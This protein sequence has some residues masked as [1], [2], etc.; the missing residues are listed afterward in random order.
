MLPF[1]LQNMP[2]FLLH[3]IFSLG[4]GVDWCW[5]VLF[6]FFSLNVYHTLRPKQSMNKFIMLLP[7]T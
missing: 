5:I 1:F 6:Y 3:A 4:K 2:S 7:L